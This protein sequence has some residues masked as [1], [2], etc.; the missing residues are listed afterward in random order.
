MMLNF[1]WTTVAFVFPLV[2]CYLRL[3]FLGLDPENF[4]NYEKYYRDDTMTQIA[5]TGVFLGVDELREYNKAG[6]VSG[7]YFS[8]PIQINNL[9]FRFERYDRESKMCTFVGNSVVVQTSSD[10]NTAANVQFRS[11]NL[12]KIGMDLEKGYVK[13]QN[14]FL[15]LG[16]WDVALR[17]LQDSDPTRA[18]I[19]DV[20]QTRCSASIPGTMQDCLNSLSA[21][22]FTTTSKGVLRFD[23]NSLACRAVH[24]ALAPNDPALHCPHLSFAPLA[25]P[26]G[27][28]KC[29]A[30]SSLELVHT[31]LFTT[32]ELDSFTTFLADS[33]LSASGTD[34]A[35]P[36]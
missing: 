19:C 23:Q 4:S 24:A 26:K 15:G 2:P 13:L 18:Y 6:S 11:G 32:Q 30:G 14:I 20:I 3:F 9:D 16:F 21:L 7:P 17:S 12:V 28:V 33:G 5:E 31:D 22:P 27:K 25:D 35:L 34:F 1:L 8:T 29:Q 36:S 10:E